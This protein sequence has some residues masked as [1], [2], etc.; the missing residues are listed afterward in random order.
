MKRKRIV[1]PSV[2]DARQSAGD[3]LAVRENRL[4]LIEA[5]M[6][7]LVLVSLYI[8]VFKTFALLATPILSGDNVWLSS[9]M[10]LLYVLLL[11]ALTLFLTLPSVVGF[12]LLAGAIERGEDVTLSLLFSPFASRRQYAR[13]LRLSWGALWKFG[14]FVLAV[15]LTP[16]I[17][18]SLF[19]GSIVADLICGV[20]V[21]VE[22]AVGILLI[23]RYFPV[24][25]QISFEN[26][27][28]REA[29][30]LVRKGYPCGIGI[31]FG[32]SFLPWILLGVLTFGVLLLWDV[33][34]R[35][36][37]AYFRYCRLIRE[38]ILN[39]HSEENKDYE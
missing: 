30:M 9:A 22:L 8:T 34:P 32:F 25:A 21:L 39:I 29:R 17:S 13:A 26:L 15:I 35:M 37:V 4:L 1:L 12:F 19:A 38:T 31:V 11:L 20:I 7:L 16:Q 33:L 3:V 28:V 23:S 27:S 36:A 18:S 10:L 6:V 2:S 24:M 14:L 5:L